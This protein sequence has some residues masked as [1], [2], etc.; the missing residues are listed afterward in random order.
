MRKVFYTKY[1]QRVFQTTRYSETD[2]PTDMRVA[3][4]KM[5]GNF[6]GLKNSGLMVLQI[7]KRCQAISDA[8]CIE[9]HRFCH[10]NE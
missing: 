10:K 3:C 8:K 4:K 9:M 2:W 5:R 6:H 7:C 1:G